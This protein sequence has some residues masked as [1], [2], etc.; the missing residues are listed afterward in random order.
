MSTLEKELN[1]GAAAGYRVAGLWYS[2]QLFAVLEKVP[3]SHD[4]YECQFIVNLQRNAFDR[5]F[6]DAVAA[7][8]LPVGVS[9]GGR[10]MALEKPSGRPVGPTAEP[11]DAPARPPGA[12]RH[13]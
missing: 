10:L 7:G 5:E 12:G 11:A 4:V 6:A 1:Q 2:G 13:A 8:Y 9:H 3:G